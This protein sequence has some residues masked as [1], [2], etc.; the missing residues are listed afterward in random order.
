MKVLP[1]RQDSWVLRCEGGDFLESS[2]GGQA[3]ILKGVALEFLFKSEHAL[4]MMGNSSHQW[5]VLPSQT[6]TDGD[7]GSLLQSRMVMIS[8]VSIAAATEAQKNCVPGPRPQSQQQT[9]PNP[10][11]QTRPA[12]C[13]VAEPSTHARPVS[14]NLLLNTDPR[15]RK[16]TQG[17]L[18]I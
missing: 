6:P 13:P 2:V 7:A 14:S 15:G 17:L 16:A 10:E 11:S 5:W 3:F 12:F 8:S 1:S 18:F 9:E 4:T